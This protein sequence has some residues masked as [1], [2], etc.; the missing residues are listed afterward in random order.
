MHTVATAVARQL[1][2]WITHT[3][4]LVGLSRNSA[5]SFPFFSGRNSHDLVGACLPVRLPRNLACHNA[6]HGPLISML[7][8]P[9]FCIAFAV[10][11]TLLLM[12]VLL[13]LLLLLLLLLLR[14]LWRVG[15]VTMSSSA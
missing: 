4:A 7:I 9:A 10:E 14:R 2:P 1:G 8:D 5:C 6:P 12:L 3:H 13:V 15:A 11:T